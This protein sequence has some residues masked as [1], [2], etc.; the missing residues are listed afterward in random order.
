MS[1]H[2]GLKRGY[3]ETLMLDSFKSYKELDKAIMNFESETEFLNLI[4]RKDFNEILISNQ[5]NDFNY[6]SSVARKLI[7][8]C[9]N[10]NV[11]DYIN[12]ITSSMFIS[13]TKI[14]DINIFKEYLLE[15]KLKFTKVNNSF[16][17][18]RLNLINGMLNILDYGENNNETMS[19][20]NSILFELTENGNYSRVRNLFTTLNDFGFL[21]DETIKDLYENNKYVL[22]KDKKDYYIN[23]YNKKIDAYFNRKNQLSFDDFKEQIYS[24]MRNNHPDILQGDMSFPPSKKLNLRG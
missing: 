10:G 5:N 8:I 12:S 2:F 13:D 11:K 16:G 15:E 1:F 18:S 21:Y 24:E 6:I 14:F 22:D 17:E 23:L 20:F 7:P 9:E 19:S 4:D 3:E